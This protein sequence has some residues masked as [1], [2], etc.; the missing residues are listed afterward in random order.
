MRERERERER[1]V[2]GPT[3]IKPKT[4]DDRNLLQMKTTKHPKLNIC[5]LCFKSIHFTFI[6]DFC[7]CE[8]RTHHPLKIGDI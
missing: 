8:N 3:D 7:V 2:S 6:G 1:C 4:R 5:A